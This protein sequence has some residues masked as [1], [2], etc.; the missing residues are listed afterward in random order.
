MIFTIFMFCFRELRLQPA[1]LVG[2]LGK[3]SIFLKDF[4]LGQERWLDSQ[5][6]VLL[7]QRT[8]IWFQVA[9]LGGSQPP[10]TLVPGEL[11]LFL[12]SLTSV[13]LVN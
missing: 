3:C 6:H 13:C 4:V 10:V 1:S 5:E 8:H 7:L 2:D 11:L 12:G 9:L